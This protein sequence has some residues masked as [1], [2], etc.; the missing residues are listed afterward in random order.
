MTDTTASEAPASRAPA[1][2]GPLNDIAE[3][4]AA[5]ARGEIIVVVDDCSPDA[6]SE[7]PM[8]IHDTVHNRPAD[9]STAVR[10]RP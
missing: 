1:D 7:R 8:T 2:D 5:F 6:T 3:A 10:R 4:L 9:A